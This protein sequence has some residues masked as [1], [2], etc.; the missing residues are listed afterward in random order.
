M[1]T[2]PGILLGGSLVAIVATAPG[3]VEESSPETS[4]W[5]AMSFDLWRLG[6]APA[7]LSTA[8]QA[9][10]KLLVVQARAA[11]SA[12]TLKCGDAR[13]PSDYE[14]G[15][16]TAALAVSR[17]LVKSTLTRED[18]A[19]LRLV[20]KDLQAKQRWAERN[21]RAPFGPVKIEAVI[22]GSQVTAARAEIYFRGLLD[23]AMDSAAPVFVSRGARRLLLSP[24]C[25]VF[26]L[27]VRDAPLTAG[28]R[29]ELFADGSTH[30]LALAA[31]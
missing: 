6:E 8:E 20:A 28:E 9:E 10:L 25:H 22:T 24:G 5:H 13:M 19:R 1:K 18:L 4:L 7:T 17:M 12:L 23:D 3:Q 15:V 31:P 30:R 11:V 27:R 21:P 2:A 26:W 29:V 16:M 14:Q